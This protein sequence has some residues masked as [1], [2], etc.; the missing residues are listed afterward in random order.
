M[1]ILTLLLSLLPLSLCSTGDR[2]IVFDDCLKSCLDTCDTRFEMPLDTFQRF[3]FWSCTDN[4][5]YNCMHK[6]TNEAIA[7]KAQVHQFYGKW[8]FWRFAGMQEPAS[9]AF[10]IGN[11][12]MHY[13]G[14]QKYLSRTAASGRYQLRPIVVAYGIVAI[15]TWVWS[16]VF[17]TRD[18]PVTEKVSPLFI[19]SLI[20]CLHSQTLSNIA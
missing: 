9:V 5:K 14:L 15:N 16:S 7:A 4:C 12:Y 2:L 8:P 6:V 17:H 11:G 20:F 3:T 19:H 1:L 13:K 10:S 18:L